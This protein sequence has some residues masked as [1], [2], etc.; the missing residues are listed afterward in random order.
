MTEQRL[1]HSADVAEMYYDRGMTQHHAAGRTGNRESVV[2]LRRPN[3]FGPR[4][5]GLDVHVLEHSEDLE[6]ASRA[7]VRSMTLSVISLKLE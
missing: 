7:A 3:S 1:E 5:H 4:K 6:H 2:L